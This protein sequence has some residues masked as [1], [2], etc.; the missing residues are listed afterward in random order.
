MLKFLAKR[1]LLAIV[2]FFGITVL[3]FVLASL[4]PGNPVLWLLASP[5]ATREEIEQI[6]HEM[7]LDQP[8]AV[9]YFRWLV[10]FL[11]GNLGISYRTFRPVSDMVA[12]RIGATLILTGTATIVALFFAVP[13]GTCAALKPYSFVDYLSSG[14]AFIG[15]AM[16]V[17]FSALIFIY[18]FCARLGV[19]PLGGMYNSSRDHSLGSLVIHLILPAGT[20]AINHM[21]SYIRQTRNSMLEVLGEDYVRTARAKGLREIFVVLRH[22]LRNALIPIV[23]QIGMSIPFL[24]GGAVVIEQIFGWPGLGSLMVASVITRDYPVIMGIASVIALVVL[25]TNIAMDLLYGMLDPRIRVR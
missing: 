12:E 20:L 23:T 7:G 10:Q 17:F 5:D 1:L 15:A 18:L 2:V 21:G 6:T 3:V 4:A 19:L 9:Q 24:I 13:L 14:L 11:Q 16:P 22:G 25:A 8:L